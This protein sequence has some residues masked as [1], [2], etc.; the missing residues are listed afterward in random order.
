MPKIRR[1][2]HLQDRDYDIL[3]HVMRYRITTPEVLHRM[4]EF[5][6]SERNAVTKVTSRLCE[7][8]FL[9]SFPLYK[10]YTY[11]T[12]GKNGARITYLPTRRVG[13]LGPQALYREYGMLAFCHLMGTPRE[14]LR[15]KELEQKFREC[16]VKGCDVSHYYSERNGDVDIPAYVWVE[17]GGTVDH[18]FNVVSRE[19]LE[20]RRRH[21]GMRERI[22]E[23][24]FALTVVTYN[25]EKRE[26]IAGSLAK[27][28]YPVYVRVEVIPEL[29]HLLPP[30]PTI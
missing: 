4:P 23:G 15:V 24:R 1:N 30:L 7:N 11:F 13:P 27:L 10:N 16:F 5:A 9:L 14:R 20:K 12:L 29:I 2:A 17:G 25:S 21:P 26:A 3:E 18:I 8:G 28:R 19:I 22:D 6:D